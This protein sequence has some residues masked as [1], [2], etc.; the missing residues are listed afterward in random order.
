MRDEVKV[1]LDIRLIGHNSVLIAGDFKA[2]LQEHER[3]RE[4][5]RKNS[6]TAG[7]QMTLPRSLGAGPRE[8]PVRIPART[9][10]DGPA[11]YPLLPCTLGSR[12]PLR[13]G[14]AC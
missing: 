2:L 9:G 7:V 4:P 12:G 11:A 14:T 6:G 13:V 8:L 3:G 1:D 10:Q 5:P